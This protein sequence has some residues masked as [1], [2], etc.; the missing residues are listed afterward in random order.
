MPS[1]KENCTSSS[2][3]LAPPNLC[4]LLM[5]SQWWSS[6]SCS[7]HLPWMTLSFQNWLINVCPSSCL[8]PKLWLLF[9]S[10]ASLQSPP[11]VT[12]LLSTQCFPSLPHMMMI[13]LEKVPQTST[14]HLD[15]LFHP[16]SLE[17][18]PQ[19][20]PRPL[21]PPQSLTIQSI[22]PN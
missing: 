17:E 4:R 7:Q 20:L 16:T 18:L 8:L 13:Y 6:K 2:P 15:P 9:F 19:R 11:F 3:R 1:F 5:S 22:P 21:H 10:C 14:I 12:L